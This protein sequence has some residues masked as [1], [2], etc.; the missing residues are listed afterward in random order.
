MENIELYDDGHASIC[1]VCLECGRALGADTPDKV[2]MPKYALANDNWIGR[3]P[4][5]FT[6]EGEPLSDMEVKSL[7]RA[8]MCVQKVIAAPERPGPRREK[9]GGLRGNNIAFPQAKV[10]MCRSHEFP[11]PV[12]EASRFMSE[13]VVIAL[14]GTNTEE[15]HNPK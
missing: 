12:E 8:R 13:T 7:A 3:V 1:Q 9:Q 5:A 15:L 14:A 2:H 6:P 11:L 4:F 10:E